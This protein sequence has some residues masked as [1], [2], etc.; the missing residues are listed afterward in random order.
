MD[1]YA[2]CLLYYTNTEQSCLQFFVRLGHHD[3]YRLLG[4]KMALGIFLKDTRRA[5]ASGIEPRFCNL[6]ITNP[7]VY[8]MSCEAAAICYYLSICLTIQR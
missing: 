1:H 3:G 8:H 2:L 5:T 4:P 7:A 6:S